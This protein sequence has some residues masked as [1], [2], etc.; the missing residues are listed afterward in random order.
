MLNLYPPCSSFSGQSDRW[1]T[2]ALMAGQVAVGTIDPNTMTTPPPLPLT[3]PPPTTPPTT[4]SPT[5]TLPP[6]PITT[7]PV[8]MTGQVVV[9]T[10]D[11]SQN[12]GNPGNTNNIGEP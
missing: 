11:P 4:T 2:C 12:G 9:G 7:S 6:P 3:T 8:L 10:T 5:T 1:T